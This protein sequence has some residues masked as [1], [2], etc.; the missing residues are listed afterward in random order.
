M[1]VMP[2]PA[3]ESLVRCLDALGRGAALALRD[4]C[5][6]DESLLISGRTVH[7]GEVWNAGAPNFR[8]GCS[9]DYCAGKRCPIGHMIIASTGAWGTTEVEAKATPF[10]AMRCGGDFANWWDAEEPANRP[11]ALA[12]VAG[13]IDAWLAK[14]AA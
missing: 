5:L 13:E 8:K 4:A 14:G 10:V 2:D 6:R 3:R 9:G 12:A 11:A 1:T 7:P